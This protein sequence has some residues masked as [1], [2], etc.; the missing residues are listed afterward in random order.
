MVRERPA[1]DPA[2]GAEA[3]GV[4]EGKGDGGEGLFTRAG[5]GTE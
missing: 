2:Q 1:G 5:V 3:R 4:S